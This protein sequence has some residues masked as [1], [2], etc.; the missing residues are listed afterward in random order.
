MINLPSFNGE[1]IKVFIKKIEDYK[2]PETNIILKNQAKR[3]VHL[4]RILLVKDT[5]LEDFRL[6]IM[7]TTDRPLQLSKESISLVL[8]FSFI[9]ILDRQS[10]KG[11]PHSTILRRNL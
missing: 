7:L 8:F 6:H 5:L 4:F 10:D 11:H 3:L 9:K 1:E 2:F